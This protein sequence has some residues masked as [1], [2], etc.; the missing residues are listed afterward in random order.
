MALL[1]KGGA[2]VANARGR[3]ERGEIEI[4]ARTVDDAIAQA[5]TQ[6]GM[7]R[8][9]VEVEVLHAGSPGRL[10]GFGAEP[11]RVRV[12]PLADVVSAPAAAPDV[13][14]PSP[15]V[16]S[17]GPR[18]P[19]VRGEEDEEGVEVGDEEPIPENLEGEAEMARLM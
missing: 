18:S 15:A 17:A 2:H 1:S 4:S 6:L 16:R 19:R 8:D 12:T 7:E 10:L 9:D 14:K 5:L 13:E 11:A 3:G